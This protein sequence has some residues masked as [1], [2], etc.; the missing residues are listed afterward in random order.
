MN[1]NRFLR[2]ALCL[3]LAVVAAHAATEQQSVFRA[4]LD[5]GLRVVVIR[6]SLAPVATVRRTLWW[7]A[8]RRRRGFRGWRTRRSTWRSADARG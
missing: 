8:M 3:L 6:N 1:G 5:N 2:V 7:A 4:K